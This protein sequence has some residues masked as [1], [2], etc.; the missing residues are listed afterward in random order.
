MDNART[1]P[2][3]WC[4]SGE[5]G[6][7]GLSEATAPISH[8]GLQPQSQVGLTT[9]GPRSGSGLQ[10]HAAEGCGSDGCHCPSTSGKKLDL[11]PE[12]PVLG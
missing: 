3:L 10:Q 9:L 6:T 4:V 12:K 1:E 2:W 7:Q 5:H 8:S 11:R